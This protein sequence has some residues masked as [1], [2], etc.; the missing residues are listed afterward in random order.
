MLIFMTLLALLCSV[1]LWLGHRVEAQHRQ[2]LARL[3]AE[4]TSR[5]INNCIAHWEAVG[6]DEPCL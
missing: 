5:Y 3:R 6:C 1:V 4:A 2:R